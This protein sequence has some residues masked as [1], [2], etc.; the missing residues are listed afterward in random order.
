VTATLEVARKE[1][2]TLRGDLKSKTKELQAATF[3]LE[4]L[5]VPCLPPH[6]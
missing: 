6:P 1:A 3:E 2:T 5:Q 4:L